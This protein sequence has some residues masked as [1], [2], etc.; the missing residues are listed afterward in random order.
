M[1]LQAETGRYHLY[2]GNACP[3][4]HR[5]LLALII[6]GLL[7]HISFTMAIDDPERASRGG[8]VFDQPEPVF[9]AKDLRYQAVPSNSKYPHTDMCACN[10]QSITCQ[11]MMTA[12]PQYAGRCM[13][14]PVLGTEGAALLHCWLISAH[15]NLSVMRAATF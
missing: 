15:G 8:W 3:W 10:L 9:N 14:Q 6:R 13:M 11:G 5:V 1:S 4:C 12:L 2:V 7:P